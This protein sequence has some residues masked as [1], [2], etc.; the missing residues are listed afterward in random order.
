M[1]P[2]ATPTWNVRLTPPRLRPLD[3][4]VH[5]ASYY[6]LC[7]VGGILSCGST[8]A[9]VTPLDLV[10]CNIQVTP[11]KYTGLLQ[12]LRVVLAEEGAA[13][14]F[15]GWVP[16]TLGYSLHGMGKFGLYEIFKD[17]FAHAAGDKQKELRG[18]IYLA[19]AASAEFLADIALCP[20]EMTKVKMQT[21]SRGTFPLKLQPALATMRATSPRFPFGSLVPLWCRQVPYTMTQ[22][23]CFEKA[24]EA[25]Y[26]HV[27]TSPKESYPISTQL[28]VTFA[29]GYAAGVVCSV[30]SHPADS[31]VSL[32]SKAEN[33]GK[34]V[35]TIARETGFARLATKG[36]GTRAAI[37]G[38]L[39]GLQWYIYDTFKA[40][41]GMGTTG[42]K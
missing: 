9:L 13:G 25:F 36:L 12:G 7:M 38:T 33:G 39:V 16:T 22:F 18:A 15:K 41:C 6:S 24:V 11:T 37:V 21:A 27:F 40:A 8:R 29:S 10:K 20:L 32:M 31:I 5:D 2:V 4:H 34:S 35:R 1:N 42:G 26:T 23:Y 3:P 28:G 19:A 17:G 30:I 14:L